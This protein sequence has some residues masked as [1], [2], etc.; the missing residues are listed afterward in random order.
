MLNE[1]KIVTDERVS[2]KNVPQLCHLLQRRIDTYSRRQKRVWTLDH[3]VSALSA[4]ICVYIIAAVVS[5]VEVEIREGKGA[6]G[7]R[8]LPS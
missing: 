1:T 4:V 3:C 5:C 7:D 6:G 8:H 2:V